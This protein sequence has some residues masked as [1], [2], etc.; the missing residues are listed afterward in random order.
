MWQVVNWR[1]KGRSSVYPHTRCFDKKRVEPSICIQFSSGTTHTLYQMYLFNLSWNLC[2]HII[3]KCLMW[4]SLLMCGPNENFP[5]FILLTVIMTHSH[6]NS[7]L[8]LMSLVFSLIWRNYCFWLS[9][10]CY[11]WSMHILISIAFHFRFVYQFY[12]SNKRRLVSVKRSMSL[13][14]ASY[15]DL[16]WRLDIEVC[17]ISISLFSVFSHFIFVFHKSIQNDV[18]KIDFEYLNSHQEINSE[19]FMFWPLWCHLLRSM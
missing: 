19:S 4:D 9:S 10:N 15:K 3:T 2:V 18:W 12:M 17:M 7:V 1:C 11:T 13:S 6:S 16:T 5:K 8:L 14:S